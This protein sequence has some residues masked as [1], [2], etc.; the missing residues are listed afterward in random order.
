MPER[1]NMADDRKAR[2]GMTRFVVVIFVLG[3]VIAGIYVFGF[4]PGEVT[5]AAP[6]HVKSVSDPT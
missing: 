4:T 2:V 3:M 5:D 6:V 1:G